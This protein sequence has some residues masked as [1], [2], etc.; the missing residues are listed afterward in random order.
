MENIERILK[1][2]EADQYMRD[3]LRKRVHKA[4]KTCKEGKCKKLQEQ[5]VA[6]S[7]PDKFIELM[8]AH[9]ECMKEC[10]E[11]EQRS[12]GLLSEIDKKADFWKN[13]NEVK[14]GLSLEDALVYWTEIEDE[15]KLLRENEQ[16]FERIE[17]KWAHDLLEEIE[18]KSDFWKNTQEVRDVMSTLDALV[19]WT[20][21]RDEFKILE[22]A[23]LRLTKEE[24]AR[25]EQLDTTIREQD[26]VCKTGK[27]ADSRKA[28]LEAEKSKDQVSAADKFFD[29][30]KQCKSVKNLHFLLG[31]LVKIGVFPFCDWSAHREVVDKEAQELDKLHER[32]DYYKNM[33][34]VREQVSIIAAVQYYD[35]IKSDIEA[36]SKVTE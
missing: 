7:D 24:I 25:K 13:F 11:K 16:E 22:Q 34:E 31:H 29:C 26:R 2:S 33:Q 36:A 32:E 23:K 14:D 27:C 15:F 9:D 10:R 12:L 1:P 8:K 20:E 35:E 3:E 17:E 18:K 6:G 30:M 28:I 4:E 19:Y 21:I 5:L